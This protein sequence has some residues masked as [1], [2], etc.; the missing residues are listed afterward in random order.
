VP[1]RGRRSDPLSLLFSQRHLFYH[2]DLRIRDQDNVH[3]G[4]RLAELAW[5]FGFSIGMWEVA[6]GTGLWTWALEFRKGRARSPRIDLRSRTPFTP[7]SI[8]QGAASVRWN[9]FVRTTEWTASPVRRACAGV[10]K[11]ARLAMARTRSAD[12]RPRA[13][14]NTSTHSALINSFVRRAL[15][16]GGIAAVARAP[17]SNTSC[18][19]AGRWRMAADGLRLAHPGTIAGAGHHRA[20]RRPTTQQQSA[21]A[22]ARSSAAEEEFA[23]VYCEGIEAVYPG[24]DSR[25]CVAGAVGSAAGARADS[26][27]VD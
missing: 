8:L 21:G 4:R 9:S 20:S 12:D 7:G 18:L 25:V 16:R 5:G 13:R 26:V 27:R 1:F 11:G 6:F 15:G 23:S 22:P 19:D 10:A 2:P 3:A 14:T 17:F 24:G